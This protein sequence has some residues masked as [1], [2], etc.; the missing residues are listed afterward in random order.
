MN[1]TVKV[2]AN[3]PSG[4]GNML[5]KNHMWID[6]STSS[7]YEGNPYNAWTTFGGGNDSEIGVSR[8]TDD[9]NTW[10]AVT[11]VSTAVNAGSH[12]QGVNIKTGPNGE[13]YVVWAV[14]DAY[15]ADENALALARSLMVAKPGCQLPGSSPILKVSG[16]TCYPRTCV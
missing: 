12:N 7:P 9:G 8:S 13:V 11:H 6:N 10:S 4:F 15:P 16:I 2:V 1:W 5:D 14:Y 3:S